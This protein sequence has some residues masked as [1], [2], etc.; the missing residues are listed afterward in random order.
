LLDDE[1]KSFI[2]DEFK[3]KH[4]WKKIF[5]I[6]S[7]TRQWVP[8]LIDYLIDTYVSEEIQEDIL[9]N[10]V[11]IYDLK[12]NVD[13]KKIN[14]QYLWNHKFKASWERLEQIIRMTDFENKEAV[15]RVYDVL[16]KMWVIREIEKYLENSEE[17][18]DN[19][20]FFEW[21]ETEDD[22]SPKVEIAGQSIPLDKLRYNI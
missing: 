13:P 18:L 21:S 15:L 5:V 20:F 12:D 17:N 10:D 7:A 11:I 8:E 16:E 19:S 1:M 22:F 6:S 9:E 14:V 4:K 3:K 2:L